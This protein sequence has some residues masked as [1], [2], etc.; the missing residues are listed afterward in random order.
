MAM[1]RAFIMNKM[2]IPTWAVVMMLVSSAV[3]TY[4]LAIELMHRAQKGDL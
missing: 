4:F 1:V 3:G 2:K